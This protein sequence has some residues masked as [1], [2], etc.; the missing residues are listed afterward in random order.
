MINCC[1]GDRWYH[2]AVCTI[3]YIMMQ[4]GMRQGDMAPTVL[5]RP[6][7][8]P[9]PPAISMGMRL[10]WSHPRVEV[11]IADAIS[12]TVMSTAKGTGTCRAASGN[13]GV[14]FEFE[15]GTPGR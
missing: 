5:G 14:T 12:V 8:V 2:L 1:R 9:S 10:M 13:P 6:G 15:P 3:M 11:P 4:K 7:A